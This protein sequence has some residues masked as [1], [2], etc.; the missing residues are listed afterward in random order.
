MFSLKLYC[1]GTVSLFATVPSLEVK[2][3]QKSILQPMR[4]NSRLI[5][6]SLGV[7]FMTAKL[8]NS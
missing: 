5:L 8:Q 2:E 1:P 6:K 3:T 4:M 7:K